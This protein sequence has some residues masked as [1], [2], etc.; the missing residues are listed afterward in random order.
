MRQ[1]SAHKCLIFN[2]FVRQIVKYIICN[3]EATSRLFARLLFPT[4]MDRLCGCIC[5]HVYVRVCV[6][7]TSEPYQIG[8]KATL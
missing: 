1:L 8:I 2:V 5:L 7:V 6:C 4:F 3:L